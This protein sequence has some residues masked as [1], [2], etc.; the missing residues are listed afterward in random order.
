MAKKQRSIGSLRQE[1]VMKSREAALAATK[2]FNDPLITFKSETFIVLMIIAWTYLLHA[3]YRSKKIDYRYYDQGPKRKRYHRT[4][5]GAYKYWELERCINDKESPVD[6]DTAN[7]LRFLIGLRH[8]IE[9]QMTRSLDSYLSGRYQACAL[10]FNDYIKNLFG[11]RYGLDQ[12][13]TYSLQFVQLTADQ[14]AGQPLQ[15]SIPE[16]LR[17]YVV[18]FDAGLG[19]DE[20]NS[21]RFSYRLLFKR[22]LVNRPGQADTVIE[23]ID[24]K[25]D[26]AKE[27]DKQY[28]VKKEVERPKFTGKQVVEAVQKT[29]FKNFRLFSEHLRMWKEEDAKNPAKGYGVMVAG[30]WYWYQNWI[31]R[32]VELCTA[33]PEKYGLL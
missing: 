18:E 21:D 10:N 25:S 27:I 32:C 5:H 8:E 3:H 12:H 17:A 20:Y 7:N 6:R 33:E 16:R 31:D 2:V 30:V 1:L 13:L 19:H 28:W 4:K 22:K 9:H 23:F 24:P 26:L 11:K 14:V 29:G 15:T